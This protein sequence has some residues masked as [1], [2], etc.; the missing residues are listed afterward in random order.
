MDQTPDNGPRLVITLR[1]N[2]FDSILSVTQQQIFNHRIDSLPFDRGLSVPERTACFAAR[3]P[4]PV[5]EPHQVDD[6]IPKGGI[7]QQSTSPAV[8]GVRLVLELVKIACQYL[9]SVPVLGRA[10]RLKLSELAR[11]SV[12]FVVCTYHRT[13]RF[14]FLKAA[15]RTRESATPWLPA[16]DTIEGADLHGQQSR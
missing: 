14:F 8:P 4:E 3:Q 12:V 16:N 9:D 15:K 1:A 13:S 10:P 11:E 2:D 5:R 6:G 7:Q